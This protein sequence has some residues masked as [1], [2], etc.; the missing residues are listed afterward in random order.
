MIER[1]AILSVHTSPLLSLGDKKAGGMNLYIRELSREFAMRGIAVDIFTRRASANTPEV[2]AI[3]GTNGLAR[4]ISVNGGPVGP[5]DPSEVYPHLSQFTAGIVSFAVRQNLRYALIYSHYWLS[6]WVANKLKCTWGVPF[7]QMFHTLGQMKNRIVPGQVSLTGLSANLPDERITTEARI[8]TWADRIVVA[9][10]A[11]SAQ[12]RWLY[13]TDRRKIAVIPPG[14]DTSR[15]YPRPKPAAKAAL[16][17]PDDVN[18]LLFVGRIEPLKGVETILRSLDELRGQRPDVFEKNHFVVIGGDPEDRTN[19]ELSRLRSLTQRLGLSEAVQF[20]GAKDH[21]Q[22]PLYYSAAV[23]AVVP[24]DYE[25]FGLVA[26][27]AMACGTPVIA[28]QVG[29]LAYLVRDGE[30]G[31]LVPVREP[32]AL[33]KSITALADDPALSERMG[34]SAA[35]LAQGYAWPSIA[36]QLLTLF[37]EVSSKTPAP[38]RMS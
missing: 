31:F 23:A 8:V 17:I 14:V 37:A 3:P 12:L 20:S 27:E 34:H 9:T 11:E 21:H 35:A 29:G 30:T 15:F 22:L 6:G 7:V 33:A 1:L 4:V 18:M 28:S 2:E 32:D 5:L 13:R 16:G 10:P 24:S 19:S 26:L 36:D 25:S 38:A